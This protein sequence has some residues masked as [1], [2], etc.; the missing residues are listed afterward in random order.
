MF[1]LMYNINEK[2]EIENEA[3]QQP[4]VAEFFHNW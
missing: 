1:A 2:M 4:S 3:V